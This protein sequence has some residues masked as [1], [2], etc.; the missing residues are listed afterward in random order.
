MIILQA[1]LLIPLTFC[2]K[3]IFTELIDTT[4]GF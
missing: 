3:L 4:R 1:R 2:L